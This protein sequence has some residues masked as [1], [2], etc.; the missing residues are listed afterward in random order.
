M[1]ERENRNEG[2]EG[3]VAGKDI[4]EVYGKRITLMMFTNAQ[5]KPAFL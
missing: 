1:N 5:I 3:R 4:K 2:Y